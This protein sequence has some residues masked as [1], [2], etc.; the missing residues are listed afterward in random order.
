MSLKRLDFVHCVVVVDPDKHVV[1]P[2]NDPLLARHKLGSSHCRCKSHLQNGVARLS[3]DFC[4][5]NP[6]ELTKQQFDCLTG[7]LFTQT[8]GLNVP[9][10]SVTSK[11]LTID[12]S[13]V[14]Q[15]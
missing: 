13:F 15:M 3:V 1:C 6:A 9:G 10:S 2:T 12:W 7:K 11:D 14:L 8:K 5:Q 4:T